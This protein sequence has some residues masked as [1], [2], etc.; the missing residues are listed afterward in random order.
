MSY[1]QSVQYLSVNRSPITF[2]FFQIS[3]EV[4]AIAEGSRPKLLNFDARQTTYFQFWAKGPYDAIITLVPKTATICQNEKRYE[5]VIGGFSNQRAWIRR[6]GPWDQ[7]L[8]KFAYGNYLS[9]NEY[10]PFWLSWANY[11]ITFGRGQRIGIDTLSF[12]DISSFPIDTNYLFVKSY[13]TSIV[14]FKYY[15]GKIF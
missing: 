3:A 2:L 10:R 12:K 14:Y 9:E 5:I 6:W 15:T 7:D 13:R 11:N 4:T 1:A 8:S